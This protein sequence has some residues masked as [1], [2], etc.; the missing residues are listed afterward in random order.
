[1]KLGRL[2]NTGTYSSMK[3]ISHKLAFALLT[4]LPWLLSSQTATALQEAPYSCT[5]CHSDIKVQY[6]TGVHSKRGIRCDSCHGGNPRDLHI[7]A[8]ARSMGFKG[9]VGDKEPPFTKR[10]TVEL[11]ASCHAN[12]KEMLQ[13]GIPSDQYRLYRISQ[14]GIALYQRGDSNVAGC[15]DCHGVHDILPPDDPRSTVYA[16]NIPK[17]CKKC[18]ENQALMSRY[19][20]SWDVYEKY[21][22]SV[23]G[24][25]LLQRND[26][27]APECARCHGVHGAAPPGVTQIGN[28]CGQCHSNTRD[29]FTQGPHKVAMD[30]R[31]MEECVS[32]HGNHEVEKATEALFDRVCKDCHASESGAYRRGQ[33]IKALLV[34]TQGAVNDAWEVVKKARAMGLEVSRYEN[35]LEDSRADIV[36]ALPVSHALSV[37]AVERV[38]RAAKSTAEDVK[39]E[40][41]EQLEEIALRKYAL[42]IGWLSIAFFT[43]VFW[44]K[45]KRIRKSLGLD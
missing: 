5:V 35:M 45:K 23:H 13:Y 1:M 42:T 38:T 40:I 24:V 29:Y 18:H 25:A 33:K 12:Q 36:R 9:N 2:D 44:L 4:P 34:E 37:E 26:R 15:I 27:R 21:A 11:C 6:E 7:T 43:G 32:C 19:G 3:H 8:H 31:G 16:Q 10:E 17:T 28:V 20:L 39:L 30:T 41:H 22:R 14:H